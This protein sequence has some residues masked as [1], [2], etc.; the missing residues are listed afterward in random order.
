MHSYRKFAKSL[1]GLSRTSPF[2]NLKDLASRDATFPTWFMFECRCSQCNLVYIYLHSERAVFAH[3]GVYSVQHVGSAG[4][5]SPG[6]N[7]VDC[8]DM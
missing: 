1:T 8:D 3:F 4:G 6:W 7:K 5:V 2:P